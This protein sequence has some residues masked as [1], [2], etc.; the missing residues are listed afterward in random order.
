MGT[1]SEHGGHSLAALTRED[2]ELSLLLDEAFAGAISAE[3][4]RRLLVQLQAARRSVA[5]LNRRCQQAEAIVAKSKAVENRPQGAQ[6]RSFGRALANYAAA[7]SKR[8]A[9][10]WR[11][12]AGR[13]SA[14]LQYQGDDWKVRAA[15]LAEFARL[16]AEDRA[17][18]TCGK[19]GA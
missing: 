5:K 7:E 3:A 17:A 11:V 12:C 13:L 1:Q 15:A 9:E 14:A 16:E 6:G 2:A 18:M 10:A 4:A 8:M 19:E